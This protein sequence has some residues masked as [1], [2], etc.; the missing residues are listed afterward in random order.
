MHGI[1]DS[2]WVQPVTDEDQTPLCDVAERVSE[3]ASIPLEAEDRFDWVCFVPRR[4]GSAG[5]LTKYFGAVADRDEYKLRGIEARQ[6]STPPFVADLQRDLLRIVDQHRTPAAVADRV[7]RALGRLDRGVVD[8]KRLVITKRVSKE[9]EAYQ[10][11]T[12]TVAALERAAEAGLS[13]HPG[14]DVSYVVVADDRRDAMRVRLAHESPS[15]YDPAFYRELV[16]RA[17]DSV[18]APL[19]WERERLTQYLND[20]QTPSL[21]AFGST[22]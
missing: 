10:Q 2:L 13:R 17:A 20:A 5:A 15:T 3:T 1:V 19:G 12:H 9:L 6:R 18:V 7:A 4:D 11:R 14:Q 16:L 22:N 8:P 21:S